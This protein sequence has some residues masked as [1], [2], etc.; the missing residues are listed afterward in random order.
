PFYFLGPDY[1]ERREFTAKRT[2]SPGG[3][4]PEGM[5]Y[6][7]Y[8]YTG[9]GWNDILVTDSRPIYLFVNPKGENRRWDLY[10]VIHEATSE[11]EVFGDVDGDG[12]PEVVYAGPGAPMCYAKPDPANP[13]AT[14]KV[15]KISDSGLA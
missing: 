6:F 4:F 7:A 14:W 13:T 10:D 1:T 3:T 15:T 9:D 11:I 8:D 2:Y 12:K 5:T